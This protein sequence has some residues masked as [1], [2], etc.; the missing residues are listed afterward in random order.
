ME[1]MKMLEQLVANE[2]CVLF[3]KYTCKRNHI[4]RVMQG[5]TVNHV[6]TRKKNTF[7][8]W[9]T[10][11]KKCSLQHLGMQSLSLGGLIENKAAGKMS[12]KQITAQREQTGNEKSKN[13]QTSA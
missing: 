2:Q 6:F 1:T 8:L 3:Y 7:L 11:I 12:L 13:D 4:S 5:Y 9:N 10:D